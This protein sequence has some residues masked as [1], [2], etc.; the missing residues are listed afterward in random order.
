ML[1]SALAAAAGS[2]CGGPGGV[3]VGA[4]TVEAVGAGATAGVLSVADWFVS[5]A[6]TVAAGAGF[7]FLPQLTANTAAPRANANLRAVW[8]VKKR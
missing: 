5:G 6:D 1:A 8:R 2:A 4:A 7:S 3:G